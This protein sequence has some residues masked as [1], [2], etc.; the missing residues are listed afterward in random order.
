MQSKMNLKKKPR[1]P[2]WVGSV[3]WDYIDDGYSP[4]CGIGYIS[5]GPYRQK[6]T[7]Y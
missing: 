4:C 2:W 7:Q 1:K 3:E 5:E 6:N